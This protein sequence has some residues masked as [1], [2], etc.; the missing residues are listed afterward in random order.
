MTRKTN[1]LSG[2]L[3]IARNSSA[4]WLLLACCLVLTAGSG[5]AQGASPSEETPQQDR[6]TRLFWQDRSDDSLKWADL[7][8]TPD[9]Q[10]QPAEV[11]QF[12]ELDVKKQDLVQMDILDGVLLVGVRDQEDGAYQSGWIAVDTGVKEV[13][14]G[15]HSDWNFVSAPAVRTSLLDKQ[16]GNPA[17]LYLY[18]NALYLANDRKNG[19]T[20]FTTESLKKS[21][22]CGQFYPGGGN[23]ITM[24][25]ADD[26][27][28]YSA[29]IDGGGPNKGRVDV[30][31]LRKP[32]ADS[33][34]YTFHLPT[35]V[36]HGATVN[37]GR[38]FFAPA[39]GVC[40]TEVDVEADQSAESVKIHHIPLGKDKESGK[41]LRTGAF[42]NHR[43]WVLFTTG[44]AD[45]SA[46]CLLDAEAAEPEV[47]KLPIDVADG[48][49][50]VTP[51][52]VR[53]RSAKRYA[54]LFQDRT[55]GDLT[56]K[57][58]IVDLDPN[59][60]RD[61]TDA[62]VATTLDV[63]ASQVEGHFGHHSVCFDPD[64]RFACL[65]N[66]GD[67]TIWVVSLKD[68]EVKAKLKVGGT[69]TAVSCIG[70]RAHH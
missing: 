28:A 35:G 3:A 64:G 44:S 13:P 16:Q 68:L 38:V 40:W 30:V 43:N 17:H 29:W 19:F 37:S 24:A 67:G 65:T 5:F 45:S 26:A 63:G 1:N 25:V 66:P 9:W 10:V 58:T 27:V 47:V 54:F 21:D 49:S 39:D 22:S 2:P 70:G 60:D 41:P 23:H 20:R 46:L 62:R 42:V 33:L 57:L 12:P 34:A 61:F 18:D 59:R 56:E 31:N 7:I 6:V 15:D 53:T 36:I 32:P 11:N 8:R 4:H 52:V 51:S 48:L 50:L 14:H 55:E 69:P